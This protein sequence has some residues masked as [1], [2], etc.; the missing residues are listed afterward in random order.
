MREERKK[1]IKEWD[2]L[3]YVTV[4]LECIGFN[5]MIVYGGIT[6]ANILLNESESIV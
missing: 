2:N 3:I 5:K 1:Y 4:I 6:W